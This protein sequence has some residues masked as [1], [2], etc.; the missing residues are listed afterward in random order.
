MYPAYGMDPMEA[1]MLAYRANAL[2]LFEAQYA[3]EDSLRRRRAFNPGQ[4]D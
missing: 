3:K 2:L 1:A 4:T